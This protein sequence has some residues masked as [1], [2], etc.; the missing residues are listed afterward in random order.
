MAPLAQGLMKLGEKPMTKYTSREEQLLKDAWRNL[1][2]DRVNG[3]FNPQ[4]ESDIQAHLYHCLWIQLQNTHKNLIIQTEYSFDRRRKGKQTKQHIDLAILKK[5]EKGEPKPILLIEIK[6]TK[7]A[8]TTR[9]VPKNFKGK[10]KN[11]IAKLRY[12]QKQK[13]NKQP[14]LFVGFFFRYPLKHINSASKKLKEVEKYYKGIN[15]LWGSLNT[16]DELSKLNPW[17]KKAKSVNES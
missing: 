1:L 9:E 14:K 6:E 4:N 2:N 17:M 15:F 13:G 7:S 5:R 11:D 3:V 16:Q 10:V 12:F 8:D